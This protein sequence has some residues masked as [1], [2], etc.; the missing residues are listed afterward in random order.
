M[1]P[2]KITQR[3]W[4]MRPDASRATT[5]ALPQKPLEGGQRPVDGKNDTVSAFLGSVIF[6]LNGGADARDTNGPQID[7]FFGKW[8]LKRERNW[9]RNPSEE[10]M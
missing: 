9:K 6:E 7:Q 10:S 3:T 2:Q 4:Q 5:A 1:R 8:P